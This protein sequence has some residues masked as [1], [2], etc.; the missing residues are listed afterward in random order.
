MKTVREN[1]FNYELILEWKNGVSGQIEID[2]AQD[3]ENINHAI[4]RISAASNCTWHP[5]ILW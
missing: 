5:V 4:L 1:C 2:Y 3:F